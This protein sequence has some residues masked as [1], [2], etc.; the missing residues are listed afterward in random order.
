MAEGH[1]TWGRRHLT[2]GRP[3]V[4][5]D[6]DRSLTATVRPRYVH[7]HRGSSIGAVIV[8]NL[9]AE[10]VA[11]LVHRRS[12]TRGVARYRRQRAPGRGPSEGDRV[13]AVG[14]VGGGM[15]LD[16]VAR[17]HVGRRHYQGVDDR[18]CVTKRRWGRCLLCSYHN[19]DH[20]AR[21]YFDVASLAAE[22][23]GSQPVSRTNG[24]DGVVPS[25]NAAD[26]TAPLVGVTLLEQ[27]ECLRLSKR[28]TAHGHD[29]L[30]HVDRRQ[31]ADGDARLSLGLDLVSTCGGSDGCCKQDPHEQPHRPMV[32]ATK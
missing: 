27:V 22:N 19:R 28:G 17:C 7:G 31:R 23:E 2:D 6:T 32:T 15:Q 25:R 20:L 26:E 4:D 13:G 10:L 12:P 8:G 11:P 9:D 1:P 14:I 3:R 29:D 30:G 21:N 18:R 16:H 5:L 24:K